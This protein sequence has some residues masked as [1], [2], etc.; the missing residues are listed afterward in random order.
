M[1]PNLKHEIFSITI[2]V[3]S[4]LSSIYFYSH[5]PE[6]VPSHWNFRGEVDAWS[7]KTMGAFMLPIILIVMY[8]MFLALPKLDPKKEK[9]QQFMKP[10]KI[11]Q[12][13][14]IF[15]MFAIYLTASFN[16]LGY[17]VNISIIVP[18]LIALLFIILGNY[19]GKLKQ[20][21]F[22][23]IK[24]PWTLSSEDV[25]NKTHRFGGKVFVIGGLVLMI[26]PFVPENLSFAVFLID[27][28]FIIFTPIIY[29]F[30]IHKK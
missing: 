18:A 13:I 21:Y 9:Y 7:G 8:G 27:I 28:I 22:V 11:F 23:G 15:I 17:P 26:V 6:R 1:K 30:L 20:N 14:I 2:I 4:I 29:S 10:Y 12:S 19:M 5:F 25:W 24:T 3:I 16:A